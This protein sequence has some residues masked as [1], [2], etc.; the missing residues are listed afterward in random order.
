MQRR[1]T[2][3]GAGNTDRTRAKPFK[4]CAVRKRACARS[5]THN[6]FEGP[7]CA[8]K[9]RDKIAAESAFHRQRDAFHEAGGECGIE[10]VAAGGVC[11]NSSAGCSRVRRRYDAR[12]ARRDHLADALDGHRRCPLDADANKFD[13][14]EFLDGISQALSPDAALFHATER[15]A[16]KA[17][18]TGLIDP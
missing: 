8:P 18:A 4:C 1:I 17:E 15:I 11:P 16:V 9:Q 14:G 3:R 6:G 13:L 10:C 2:V 7:T 5:N 12:A